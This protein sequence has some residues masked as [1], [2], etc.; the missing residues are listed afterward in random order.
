MI[1][2]MT[3]PTKPLDIYLRVSSKGGREG[4]RY[5]SPAEQETI[6]RTFATAKGLPVGQVIDLDTHGQASGGTINRRDLQIGLDRVRS[7]ESGGIIVAWID[8]LSRDVE[9][10]NRLLREISEAG[11]AVYAPDMPEDISTSE[12]GLQVDLFLAISQYQRRRLAAGLRRAQ[13]RAINEGRVIRRDFVGYTRG[14]DGRLYVI[15][16]H[17]IPIREAF[18]MRAA[19]VG[20][21]EIGRHLTANGVAT[22]RGSP[23]WS[24]E[25]VKS[26]L[27]SRAPLGEARYGDF[28]K[29]GAHEAIVD[30]ALWQAAQ[31][32]GRSPGPA[33]TTYLLSGILRCATCGYAMAGTSRGSGKN[34]HV[35]RCKGHHAAGT[36]P[37]PARAPGAAIEAFVQ[38]ASWTAP[39]R[40]SQTRRVS[41]QRS[42]RRP[43]RR[44]PVSF[45]P[46]C[47]RLRTHSEP[48]GPPS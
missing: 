18:E 22:S 28:I 8:R 5:Q 13:E 48:T 34:D 37:E 32:P 41:S 35:Y 7:G 36:C 14:E 20:L 21:V 16:E 10:G 17:K 27:R 43:T 46:S 3:K 39:S 44:R 40:S 12:G 25:A 11:G 6:C 47:P 4:A 24:H 38:D 15:E 29:Q 23:T 33:K 19:G 31:R 9:Q 45:R 42:R 1:G 26:L 2:S 30:E